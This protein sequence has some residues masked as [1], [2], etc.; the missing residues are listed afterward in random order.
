MSTKA[1]EAKKRKTGEVARG[2][3]CGAK[4]SGL[5]CWLLGVTLPFGHFCPCLVVAPSRAGTRPDPAGALPRPQLPQ[6]A[7]IELCHRPDS[8][9]FA[10]APQPRMLVW[11]AGA[12]LHAG[13]GAANA[14]RALPEGEILL[15][16][17]AER[18]T[19]CLAQ[20]PELAAFRQSW[21]ACGPLAR[22][23][24][25]WN[26]RSDVASG[27][28]LHWHASLWGNIHAPLMDLQ[29]IDTSLGC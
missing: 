3:R 18:Q 13:C 24:L 16:L 8:P 4:T 11:R 26:F 2:A 23:S 12:C 27:T 5:R 17:C 10:P 21:L 19:C 15:W 14:V 29:L 28:G 7:C 25:V 20:F 6:Q 9:S 22:W 1:L